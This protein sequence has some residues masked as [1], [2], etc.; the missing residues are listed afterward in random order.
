MATMEEEEDPSTSI[1]V[2]EG[3]LFSYQ[4]CKNRRFLAFVV[5]V[6][7]AADADVVAT[8]SDGLTDSEAIC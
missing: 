4:N 7:V 6:V 5:V 8:R 2:Q 1:G 3:F